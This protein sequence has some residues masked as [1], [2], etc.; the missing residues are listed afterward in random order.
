MIRALHDCSKDVKTEQLQ[1]ELTL[2]AYAEEQLFPDSP[3]LEERRERLRAFVADVEC[4]A[5]PGDSW[6]E[7][8]TIGTRG[9]GLVRAGKIVW[10]TMTHIS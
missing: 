4:L 3:G 10:A 5:L 1:R 7:W 6:W 8:A 2:E 9:L